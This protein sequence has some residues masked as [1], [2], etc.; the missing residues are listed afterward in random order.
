MIKL[1]ILLTLSSKL[2]FTACNIR[3]YPHILKL[4][5]ILDDSVIQ[6]SDCSK[7][8]QESFINFLNNFESTIKAKHLSSAI[9]AEINE[10]INISPES[11]NIQTLKQTIENSLSHSGFIINKT[12]TLSSFSSF[13]SNTP[14]KTNIICNNCNQ[15]GEKNF[16]LTVDSQSIWVSASFNQKT[17][18]YIAK[19]AISAGSKNLKQDQFLKKEI[20]TNTNN[21]LFSD[22]EN[23]DYYKVMRPIRMN[24]PLSILDVTPKTIIKAN[25]LV[26]VI[27][28]NSSISLK[29]KA[30]A[31]QSARLGEE[32]ELY[33][34]KTKKRISG[35]AVDYNKVMVRL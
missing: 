27:L 16:K 30:I 17:F 1:A 18:A 23:I 35:K 6:G 8:A 13:N 3:L 20:V 28:I 29:M 24:Q 25:K 4:N 31:R 32:V 2:A 5:S 26:D 33:N 7:E 9:S 14:I 34:P 12:T 21:Q 11:I 19:S 22:F 15:I 10:Q